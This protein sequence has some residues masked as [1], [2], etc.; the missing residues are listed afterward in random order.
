MGDFKVSV[1]VPTLVGHCPWDGY[2]LLKGW[3]GI[4]IGNNRSW[5]I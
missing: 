1:I 2:T 4:V 5:V 3:Q